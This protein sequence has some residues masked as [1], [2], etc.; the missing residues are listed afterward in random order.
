MS[1][2][3]DQAV[4]PIDFVLIEFPTSGMTG[5]MAQ[6]ILDLVDQGTIRLLDLSVIAKD[7]AGAVARLE[8]DDEGL[9]AAFTD[10]SGAESGL[11]GDDDIA[12]AAAAMEPG[13]AAALIVYENTW[14][15]PFVA[16]ARNSGGEMVASGR[17]PAQD[18]MDV[19]D[20]LESAD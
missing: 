5:E 1:L 8:L 11:L 13:T 2:T 10:L 3:P 16:A 15:A 9:T 18:V 14:A 17:I 6:A 19:I 7:E 4:G 12:E 20:A